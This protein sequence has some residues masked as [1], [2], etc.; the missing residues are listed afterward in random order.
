MSITTVL[1]ALYALYALAFLALYGRQRRWSGAF[2]WP[3]LI[4][5]ALL[6]FG[7]AGSWFA[8]GGLLWSFVAAFGLLLV[9]SDIYLNRIYP[10]R[11]QQRE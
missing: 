7:G 11:R 10:R 4:G 5:G 9:L 6:A 8:W 2:G 1:A 3:L